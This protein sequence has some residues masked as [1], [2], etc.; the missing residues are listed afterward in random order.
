M[1]DNDS[2]SSSGGKM[3]MSERG[4][5]GAEAQSKA[6]K[7]KGGRNSSRSNSRSS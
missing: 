4:R 5:K 1:A 2:N 7:A 3:S 6:D